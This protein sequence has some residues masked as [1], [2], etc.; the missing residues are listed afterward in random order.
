MLH[1]I[2]YTILTQL[3]CDKLAFDR[4]DGFRHG[5]C[6]VGHEQAYV[7]NAVILGSV[8]VWPSRQ[9]G[10]DTVARQA[11]TGQHHQLVNKRLPQLPTKS[12]PVK[13]GLPYQPHP[14]A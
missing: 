5:L 10:D 2:G 1:S 12:K 13:P 4:P 6:H 11:N 8:M 9:A 7:T 3:L 14:V